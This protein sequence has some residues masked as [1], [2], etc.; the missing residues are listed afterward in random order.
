MLFFH[1]LVTFVSRATL[2]VLSFTC[3][4]CASRNLSCAFIR[5]LR[6]YLAQ[7]MLFFHLIVTFVSRATLAV[8]SFACYVCISRNFSCSFVCLLRLYL[9]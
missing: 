1:L 8:L 9:A 3:Y 2:A 7:L 6:L 4:V 5:L